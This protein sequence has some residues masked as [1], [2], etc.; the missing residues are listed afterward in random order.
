[1]PSSSC[2]SFVFLSKV[3]RKTSLRTLWLC[4]PQRV[5]HRPTQQSWHRHQHNQDLGIIRVLLPRCGGRRR[6]G[7]D[8][9]GTRFSIT[10]RQNRSVQ[11]AIATIDPQA[12]TPISYPN[13]IFDE[14][15]QRW[16]SDAE[17]AEIDYT[18][19]TSRATAEHVTA[20][21]IVRRVKRLQSGA[22]ASGQGVL[23]DTYRYHAVFTNTDHH[24]A[25]GVSAPRARHHRRGPRRP[26]GRGPSPPTVGAVR[27]QRRLVAVRVMAF[28]LTRTAGA[29]ASPQ[30]HLI[31]SNNHTIS[32]TSNMPPAPAKQS[33][34]GRWRYETR[35]PTVC[36]NLG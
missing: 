16:L 10:A 36:F 23:F 25:S 8:P 31:G 34:P 5:D 6:S 13:A 32:P 30:R 3:E 24:A 28:N 9:A 7:R 1:V 20:R 15:E 21:L 14:A 17:V 12:W 33:A 18:A 11:A 26:A 35:S 19:F 22:K 27:G 29:M 4:R 2:S